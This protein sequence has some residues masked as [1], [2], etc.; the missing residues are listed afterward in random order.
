V[1][2]RGANSASPLDSKVGA[3]SE[4][5]VKLILTSVATGRS[6]GVC[7]EGRHGSLARRK[8]MAARRRG[9][10]GSWRTPRRWVRLLPWAAPVFAANGVPTNGLR[11]LFPLFSFSPFSFST[12]GVD[13]GGFST[14]TARVGRT[15]GAAARLLIAAGALGHM[16]GHDA[17]EARGGTPR[18]CHDELHGALARRRQRKGKI[19]SDD[20]DVTVDATVTSRGSHQSATPRGT[21]RQALAWQVSGPHMGWKGVVG[22]L[23]GST[24]SM[25]LRFS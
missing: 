14:E 12:G 9:S 20:G 11:L 17:A 3:S 18:R 7:E 24:Y 10:R 25:E 2:R 19:Q 4:E 16:V 5:W 13:R 1:W 23:I 15:R 8:K 6:T 22:Q 21:G